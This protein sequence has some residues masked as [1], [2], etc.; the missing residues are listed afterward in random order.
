MA[1]EIS[2]KTTSQIMD[3]KTPTPKTTRNEEIKTGFKNVDDYSKY[4]QDKYNYMNAGS[5]SM[6]GIPTTVSVSPAFLKKCKDDP[7]KAEGLE[8][9]LAALPKCNEIAASR[10][11]GTVTNISYKIDSNGNMSMTISGNSDPDG[12][13]AKENAKR[14][15]A[16][17]KAAKEKLEKKRADKKA[18]E[19]RIEKH[20]DEMEGI[21]EEYSVSAVG[22]D[23]EDITSQLITSISS[24]TTSGTVGFDVKA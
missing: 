18:E 4:L 12:K 11:L 13:I 6:K 23:V 8:K 9:N 16:E 15:A 3:L 24:G 22:T 19:E 7:E 20:R 10:C 14:K 5:V 21:T 2:S 1:I 17:E